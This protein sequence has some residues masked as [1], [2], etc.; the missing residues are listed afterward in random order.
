MTT[1]RVLLGTFFGFPLYIEVDE[2]NAHMKNELV[3]AF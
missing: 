1:E 3:A 2:R